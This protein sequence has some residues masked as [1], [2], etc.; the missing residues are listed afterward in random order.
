ME[1]FKRGVYKNYIQRYTKKPKI[2]RC[3]S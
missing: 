2:A 3:E 1:F